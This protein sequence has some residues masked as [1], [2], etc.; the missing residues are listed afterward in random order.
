MSLRILSLVII[1][2]ATGFIA[3]TPGMAEATAS[4]ET[5]KS[6]SKQE[7]LL[8]LDR[9]EEAY[10]RLA[11]GVGVAREALDLPLMTDSGSV[12][13][14]CRTI[15]IKADDGTG[16]SLHICCSDNEPCYLSHIF[17]CW[18]KTCVGYP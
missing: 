12:D 1:G 14:A 2:F 3:T 17:V 16:V 5:H 7:I 10:P 18:K 8:A 4:P 13:G 11:E 9:I 15:D 6:V